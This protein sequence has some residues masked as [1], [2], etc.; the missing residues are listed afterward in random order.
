MLYA[1]NTPERLKMENHAST[2]FA[3]T[4]SYLK[5]MVHAYNVMT[6]KWQAPTERPALTSA[7]TELNGSTWTP[8][9]RRNAYPA[10]TAPE[11]CQ[12]LIDWLASVRRATIRNLTMTPASNARPQ[13][14]LIPSKL[15]V[16][17]QRNLNVQPRRSTGIA[18]HPSAKSARMASSRDLLRP[19]AKSRRLQLFHALSITNIFQKDKQPV[20]N[21]LVIKLELLIAAIATSPSARMLRES[22]S[23]KMV[24]VNCAENKRLLLTTK[25]LAL[26]QTVKVF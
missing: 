12:E 24:H 2:Q 20:L 6:A 17:S 11:R 19:N 3:Q 18:R 21:A 16:F 23:L 26:N 5:K 4:S 7:A 25:K 1:M 9:Q 10:L 13:G 15:H 14:N 8:N 22:V